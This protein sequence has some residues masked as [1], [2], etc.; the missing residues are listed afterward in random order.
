LFAAQAIVQRV[1]SSI[2]TTFIAVLLTDEFGNGCRHSA[3]QIQ[4]AYDNTL[5]AAVALAA[6]LLRFTLALLRSQR[7]AAVEELPPT[8]VEPG[9]VG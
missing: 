4:R 6:M 7:P 2:A 3:G 8:R 5:W 9:V 1:G